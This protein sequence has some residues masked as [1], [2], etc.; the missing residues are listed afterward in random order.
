[1]D[2]TLL[3]DSKTEL[4]LKF[5]QRKFIL[6]AAFLTLYFKNK[7]ILASEDNFRVSLLNNERKFKTENHGISCR[8]SIKY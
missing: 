2:A 8:R 4:G 6:E 1:M 3:N 7:K 5:A